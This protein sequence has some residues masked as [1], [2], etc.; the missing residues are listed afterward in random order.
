MLAKELSAYFYFVYQENVC[1]ETCII[2][3]F[4]G[5]NFMITLLKDSLLDYSA[6]IICW[7]RNKFL[8]LGN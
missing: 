6:Q 7:S 8:K 1:L 4:E 2:L 5:S 3:I